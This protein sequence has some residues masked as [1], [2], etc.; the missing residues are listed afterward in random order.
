MFEEGTP[1]SLE[2]KI[3]QGHANFAELVA[4]MFLSAAEKEIVRL[5]K[6]KRPY[7]LLF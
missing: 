5:G 7:L 6:R 3:L 2:P 4:D 1:I